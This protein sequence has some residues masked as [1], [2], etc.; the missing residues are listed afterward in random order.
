MVPIGA[1]GVDNVSGG[2][3]SEAAKAELPFF[4]L[5]RNLVLTVVPL[6]SVFAGGF[7]GYAVRA[8]KEYPVAY[9]PSRI[10]Q[11]DES[12]DAVAILEKNWMRM[13]IFDRHEE[14]LFS[15]NDEHSG[16]IDGR[17]ALVTRLDIRTCTEDELHEPNTPNLSLIHI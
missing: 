10:T 8:W 17:L 6:L 3:L 7:L 11:I 16:F 13:T 9:A 14:S 1:A 4:T 2:E 15:G 12:D 5:G